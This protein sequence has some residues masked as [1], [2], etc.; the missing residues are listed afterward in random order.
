MAMIRM[1]KSNLPSLTFPSKGSR[2]IVRQVPG[3]KITKSPDDLLSIRTD[4][5]YVNR[6][7]ELIQ[8]MEK[9]LS[10]VY[11]KYRKTVVRSL[12]L[13]PETVRRKESLAR[14][15]LFR[16]WDEVYQRFVPR[17]VRLGIRKAKVQ[18]GK[19]FTDL[20]R[21]LDA[22]ELTPIV[23]EFYIKD[24]LRHF[25]NLF[26]ERLD[27]PLKFLDIEKKKTRRNIQ[28]QETFVDPKV[29]EALLADSKLNPLE[30][31]SFLEDRDSPPALPS[32]AMKRQLGI[33]DDLKKVYAQNLKVPGEYPL[34]EEANRINRLS[35]TF[36]LF[37][38]ASLTLTTCD[39][40]VRLAGLSYSVSDFDPQGK[41]PWPG[42]FLNATVGVICSSKCRCFLK[43]IT[44]NASEKAP[45]LGRDFTT[46]GLDVPSD[47][48]VDTLQRFFVQKMKDSVKE[49]IRGLPNNFKQLGL[50]RGV[51][52]IQFVGKDALAD[53]IRGNTLLRGAG[54]LTGEGKLLLIVDESLPAYKK[55]LQIAEGLSSYRLHRDNILVIKVFGEDLAVIAS[56]LRAQELKTNLFFKK[57]LTSAERAQWETGAFTDELIKKVQD[58]SQR[59]HL[60][61]PWKVYIEKSDLH[62]FYMTSYLTSPESFRKLPGSRLFQDDLVSTSFDPVPN[63]K[64]MERVWKG[65]QVPYRRNMSVADIND[66]E[67]KLLTSAI[68]DADK[69]T[70]KSFVDIIRRTPGLQ[71]KEFFQNLDVVLHSGKNPL[72]FLF[73]NQ[74]AGMM[75]PGKATPLIPKSV[76]VD[77]TTVQS[78]KKLVKKDFTSAILIADG[79]DVAAIHELGHTIFNYN[80]STEARRKFT[81]LYR[82]WI[83]GLTQEIETSL[84]V[85]KVLPRMTDPEQ[86]TIRKLLA[87]FRSITETGQKAIDPLLAP[88]TEVGNFQE[89]IEKSWN[90]MRKYN[91]N[92]ASR[93]RPYVASTPDEFFADFFARSTMTPVG[94]QYLYPEAAQFFEWFLRNDVLKEP[95]TA[96]L[97]TQKARIAVKK[98]LLNLR[99]TENLPPVAEEK[100]DEA[101]EVILELLAGIN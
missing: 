6:R 45:W 59:G 32:D 100:L 101:L 40:C 24:E 67:R 43:P 74:Q 80:L 28:R 79:M 54:Y 31:L 16:E 41:L 61:F 71:R 29:L 20:V 21:P 26:K 11:R 63:Q 65:R 36:S 85:A 27:I 55:T 23:H 52:S 56:K 14:K 94:A 77:N 37:W 89:L 69:R 83:R 3:A 13:L 73:E 33:I 4:F 72:S 60:E 30:Y 84:D 88:G 58:L 96:I 10:R 81:S 44:L 46:K 35:P 19:D 97:P 25:K 48:S 90:I 75:L 12:S 57:A 34:L 7:I 62:D 99:V 68:D 82:T 8:E 76:L 95:L 17:A 15:E 93:F 39:S 2:P 91:V 78:L 87:R 1:G 9:H 18:L 66:L 53:K 42:Q 86:A 51:E 38:V 92:T 70:I 22:A 5:H 47:W 98:F 64:Y 49:H 50:F